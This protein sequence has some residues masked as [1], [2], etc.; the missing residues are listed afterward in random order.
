MLKN[1][2]YQSVTLSKYINKVGLYFL[3]LLLLVLTLLVTFPWPPQRTHELAAFMSFNNCLDCGLGHI[4]NG[5]ISTPFYSVLKNLIISP[6]LY[7]IANNLFFLFCSLIFV[8]LI[9]FSG[10]PPQRSS[11]GKLSLAFLVIVSAI[12]MMGH[13]FVDGLREL[14]FGVDFMHP[15]FS[16]RTFLSLC[17]FICSFFTIKGKYLSAAIVLS[18]GSLAHPTNGLFLTL[19]FLSIPLYLRAIL[20]ERLSFFIIFGLFFIGFLGVFPVLIKIVSLPNLLSA[21]SEPTVSTQEYILAMYRDEIDDFSAI[22][23]ILVHPSLFLMKLMFCLVP[24]VLLVVL[25]RKVGNYHYLMRLAP[26]IVLPFIFFFATALVEIVYQKYN[27]L[28]KIME[29]I[30]NSQIGCRVIKYAGLPAV[31]IWFSI[32]LY[33]LKSISKLKFLGVSIR[34]SFKVSDYIIY[35]SIL[36]FVIIFINTADLKNAFNHSSLL[37]NGNM[38]KNFLSKGRSVYYEELL[39]AGYTYNRV[40]Q[41]YLYDCQTGS[42]Y[43]KPLPSSLF[44][45][46][47]LLF[48]KRNKDLLGFVDNQFK[49]RYDDLNNR[50]DIISHIKSNVPTGAGIITPPYFYCFREFLPNYDIYFQEH[51]DGNFM[52]GAKHLYALFKQRMANLNIGYINL[53]TQSSGLNIDYI[54]R[55]WLSLQKSSFFN[56]KNTE[57]SFGYILTESSH[58]L[59]LSLVFSNDLWVLYQIK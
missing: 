6:T 3:T 28:E 16:S 58:K 15:S 11:L 4:S 50:L 44:E 18:L 29:K 25:G 2:S 40:N 10:T 52:L 8:V 30:I 24:L 7:V 51:D 57:P 21:F 12:Q 49:E 14:G 59:D 35:L 5:L 45:Q 22:Y 53:P 9:S 39:S 43:E 56:I 26:L 34:K 36:I 19:I 23:Q 20:N 54:R 37:S 47:N 13:P 55:N 41:Q 38:S 1:R 33:F 48:G 46:S 17:F 27:I 42:I 31:F 32:F